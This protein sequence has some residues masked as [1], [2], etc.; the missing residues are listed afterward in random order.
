MSELFASDTI[1]AISLWQPWASLW[2]TP[3]KTH[4]TRHWAV[5]S[6][7][8]G[9]ECL[10][11]AAKK[12][13]PNDL[14]D[15]LAELCEGYFGPGW[16]KALPRGAFLGKL[17]LSGVLGGSFARPA[18]RADEICGYFGPGRFIWEGTE[19]ETFADPVPAIGRQ[20]F[21]RVP[22]SLLPELA[23]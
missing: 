22:R 19:K 8:W 23:A 15:D 11:H 13:V 21:W 16:R 6:K 10:V 14:E 3:L 2:L 17:T 1:L 7:H 20:G 4:E 5:H 12:P 18:D 9:A